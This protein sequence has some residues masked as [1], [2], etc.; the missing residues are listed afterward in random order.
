MSLSD[1]LLTVGQVS[2]TDI[3]QAITDQA[4]DQWRVRLKACILDTGRHFE[5]LL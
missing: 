5:R 3:Q 4:I 1:I 2:S